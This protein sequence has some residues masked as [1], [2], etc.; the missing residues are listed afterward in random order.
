LSH[1]TFVPPIQSH[2]QAGRTGTAVAFHSFFPMLTGIPPARIF[3]SG[4]E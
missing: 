3:K 4:G 1:R 2:L